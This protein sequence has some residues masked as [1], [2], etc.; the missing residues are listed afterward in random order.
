[1]HRIGIGNHIFWEQVRHSFQGSQSHA[2]LPS[3]HCSC[4]SASIG[5]G[6]RYWGS[7]WE[8]L[9][10]GSV[11]LNLDL[12][13]YPC[14]R[15]PPYT[16]DHRVGRSVDGHAWAPAWSQDTWVLVLGHHLILESPWWGQ[17][18]WISGSYLWN[19]RIGSLWHFFH[20]YFTVIDIFLS[21]PSVKCFGL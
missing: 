13:S 1:M 10:N 18:P 2:S 9:G 6:K 15:L 7:Q 17:L 19:S 8:G 4:T 20:I 16:I 11:T 5:T 12:E 21:L 14:P 3:L